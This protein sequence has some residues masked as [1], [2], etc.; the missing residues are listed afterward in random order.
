MCACQHT[1]RS[2]HLYS[3]SL[4]WIY[5]HPL[6]LPLAW[7]QTLAPRDCSPLPATHLFPLFLCLALAAIEDERL[8]SK[9]GLI[10][11][12]VNIAQSTIRR[13]YCIFFVDKKA[14][15]SIDSIILLPVVQSVVDLGKFKGCKKEHNY[16]KLILIC[17][18]F[19][20]KCVGKSDHALK[21]QKMYI[22]NLF[23]PIPPSCAEKNG[24]GMK[25]LEIGTAV[26][27]RHSANTETA[28]I[29]VICVPP[30]NIFAQTH[31]PSDIHSPNRYH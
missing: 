3:F 8:E 4:Y 1:S 15:N 31:F 6:L 5:H 20:S 9:Y 14:S 12:G 29:T 11:D 25:P 17:T 23:G 21:G 13:T 19:S 28:S 16:Y 30:R 27:I 7:P 18:I 10:Y 22:Q 24:L 2:Y 26:F